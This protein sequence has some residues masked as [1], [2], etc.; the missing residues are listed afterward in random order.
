MRKSTRCARQQ[1]DEQYQRAGAPSPA[2]RSN[3]RDPLRLPALR[4]PAEL[5]RA[6]GRGTGA[7]ASLAL[8]LLDEG[9]ITQDDP[10]GVAAL[11]TGGL[12]CVLDKELGEL[13]IVERFEVVIGQS[14][15]AVESLSVDTNSEEEDSVWIGLDS[16]NAGGECVIGKTVMHLEAAVPGL[17]QAA[18]YIIEQLALST[19]PAWTP[20]H[21]R[22]MGLYCM[23]YGAEDQESWIEEI[24]SM[25]GDPDD[26]ELSPEQFEEHF[27]LAWVTHPAA[28]EGIHKVIACAKRH[29]DDLVR[30]VGR[31]LGKARPLLKGPVGFPSTQLV[32]VE[33]VYRSALVRWDEDDPVLRVADDFIEQANQ[34]G[35]GY[36]EL[37]AVYEVVPD[38]AGFAAW[39]DGFRKGLVLYKLLD[40][41]LATLSCDTD[42]EIQN[43]QTQ[44]R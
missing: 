31:L 42:Q 40:G 29:P 28:P 16:R 35:D 9:L 10:R 18:M 34:C 4:A 25:G 39:L 30:E 6:P 24:E 8:A 21:A 5:H 14:A 15:H 1:V 12:E 41:L 37:Y 38:G 27:G 7:L 3:P 43:D 32:E 11:V 22:E 44:L 20:A 26:F 2:I 36:S 13:K 19:I 33:P 23:W 17:G